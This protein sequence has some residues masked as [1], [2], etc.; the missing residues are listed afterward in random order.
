MKAWE[1]AKQK[2]QSLSREDFIYLSCP[3]IL[4]ILPEPPWYNVSGNICVCMKRDY[5][6]CERCWERKVNCCK[7]D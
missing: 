3:H 2:Y 6:Q 4:N 5:F 7:K 1:V